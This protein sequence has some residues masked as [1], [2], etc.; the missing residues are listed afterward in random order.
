MAIDRKTF[1]KTAGAAGVALT[2]I[3]AL[4]QARVHP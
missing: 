1:L 3:P 4:V 2:G